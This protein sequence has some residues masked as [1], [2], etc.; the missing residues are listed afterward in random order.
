MQLA[1]VMSV[2]TTS[3]PLFCQSS[4]WLKFLIIAEISIQSIDTDSLFWKLQKLHPEAK[5]FLARN[6]NKPTLIP[7]I[8]LSHGFLDLECQGFLQQCS[9]KMVT[10][11]LAVRST[12]DYTA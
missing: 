12:K 2:S 11:R 7:G 1:I 9:E 5:S 4:E 6:S 8:P 10:Q 3:L